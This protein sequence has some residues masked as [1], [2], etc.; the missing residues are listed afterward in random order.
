MSAANAQP[1]TDDYTINR[2]KWSYSSSYAVAT[3]ASDMLRSSFS[4]RSTS[5]SLFQLT[6][7]LGIFRNFTF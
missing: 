3:Y 7:P 4:S 6:L 5:C 2:K 1:G